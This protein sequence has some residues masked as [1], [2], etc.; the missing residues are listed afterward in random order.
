[1][2]IDLI[3]VG[4][5]VV[6]A[7]LGFRQGLRT[8]ALVLIGF[9]AGAL[10]GSRV[11]PLVLQGGLRDPFAPVLALPAALLFGAVLAAVLERFGFQLKRRLRKI[12]WLD[13]L[14]GALLAACVGAVMVWILAAVGARVD[15]L[16]ASIRDS[17]IIAGLNAVV[18]PPGP[19]L[20][21]DR[22]YDPF[23]VIAGPGS[24]ERPATAKI[25]T[26]PQVKA[27]ARSV[28]KVTVASC[29]RGRGSGSGWIADDGIVVT[30]AHVVEDTRTIGVK[31]GGKGRTYNAKPI[32]YDDDEDVA[33]LR[34][35]GVR[36]RP[37]LP[38]DGRPKR[39]TTAALLGFPRGGPYKVRPA[40]LGRRVRLPTIRVEGRVF[41]RRTVATMRAFARP[42][43]SGGPVVDGKGRVVAMVFAARPGGLDAY[44]VPTPVVQKALKRAGGPADTGRCD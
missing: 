11:A 25:K 33:I 10:L 17:S 15:S 41:R 20:I 26:D 40:K 4:V 39:G 24:G 37:A 14:G 34:V 27:A 35:P 8:G 19:L 31:L 44:G 3:I 2:L 18:P 42:G 36:G 12:G 1:V 43:N 30:N 6:A 9:G 32:W 21:A 23:P 22:P 13:A 29:E 7:V 16:K 28:V 5:L 38:I